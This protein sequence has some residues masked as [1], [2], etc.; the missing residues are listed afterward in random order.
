[1][2]YIE[3]ENREQNL[4]FPESLDEYVE[5]E[6]PLRL[7][8]TFVE[9]LDFKNLEFER[10][11]PRAERRPEYNPRDLMKLYI[12]S[13]YYRLR[14]SRPLARECKVNLEIMWLIGK[15]RPDFRP[16]ANFRK[17]NKTA[18]RKVFKEFN[19]SVIKWTSSAMTESRLTE[20][21]SRR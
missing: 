15:F 16:I 17:D 13:Y 14:S 9:S 21:S 19:R 6:S 2:G 18:I 1:M 5:K 4:L 8:D 11:T 12:Y 20:V 10:E 3:G 7:F